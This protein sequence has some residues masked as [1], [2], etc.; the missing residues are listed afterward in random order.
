MS[1][2]PK[3][4]V[5]V[6][7]HNYG[8]FVEK[9]IKS[10]L[11]QT[12]DNWELLLINDNSS[13]NTKEVFNKYSDDK[14]IRI[15]DTNG[16]G[17]NA[18]CNHAL[19]N[20]MGEYLIRLDGDDYFDENILLILGNYMEKDSSLGIVYSD[21]FLVDEDG[22]KFSYEF[23]RK[24][25]K[26]ENVLEPPNGACCLIDRQKL[27]RIGGYSEDLKAQD[28]LDL[29]LKMKDNYRTKNVNLPLYYYR[30]H[31]KNLTETPYK[32]I[33]ARQEIKDRKAKPLLKS[34]APIIAVIPCRK[35][36]DFVKSLWS[37]EIH[38]Q[39]LLERDV[40]TCIKSDYFSKIIITSDENIPEIYPNILNIDPRVSFELREKN[41]TSKST[42]IEKTLNQIASK[43]D[44]KYEG[45]MLIRYIQTPFINHK[46]LEEAINSLVISNN[47]S[48]M[49]VEKI[50]HEIFQNKNEELIQLNSSLLGEI[51]VS[52]FYRDSATCV[53]FRS[54]NLLS[55]YFRGKQ[56]L[57]FPVSAAESFFINSF[58]D[59][60][61]A[62][63]SGLLNK[64]IE[65]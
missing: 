35:N 16:I 20:A 45:I 7:S 60:D 62:R 47:D 57:G 11:S 29:W 44:P 39:T 61:I 40:R 34:V 48:T 26:N 2:S 42:K 10:V 6:V 49:A 41:L 25:K 4:S 32:I 59:L 27:I 52:D 19:N 43:Y 24:I 33:N 15:F 46:T 18:V 51:N 17:L 28:G 14:R 58:Q 63:Y 1:L 53:A 9:A 64:E 30:R 12:V 36:F 55:G 21:F 56:I 8:H 50:R 23:T 13:D 37:Q 54:K 3:Y 5:Y 22:K 38:G 65:I 31:G